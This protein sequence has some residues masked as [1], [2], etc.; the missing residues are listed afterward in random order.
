MKNILILCMALIATQAV[1]QA[2]EKIETREQSPC[3]TIRWEESRSFTINAKLSN[4]T[5]IIL[6]EKIL[7]GF[8][9]VVGNPGLWDVEGA[10]A[11]LY[12]KPNSTEGEGASTTISVVGESGA[13]YDFQAVRRTD[14]VERCLRVSNGAVF[15]GA[16]AA[17]LNTFQPPE[18]RRAQAESTI[19]KTKY[20]EL[21]AS[22]KEQLSNA[23]TEALRRYRY[24]I[25][26]RYN[27]QTKKGGFIGTNLVSDV[28]DDGRFT[29]I[30][31]INDNKGLLTV[32]A[33]L[34]GK[35]EVVDARYDD[36][37]R[38]YRII[39]IYPKF[40][41]KYGDSKLLINRE[42]NITEG[43]F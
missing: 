31:L 34:S 33:D 28:Y 9:P 17:A 22:H 4:Y 7:P 27:W 42:N 25:Y 2:A 10:G 43:S 19:W 6:P 38:M 40:T 14:G 5:H 3:V 23:V 32:E 35:T 36:V 37:S 8:I 41:M 39:G 15:A 29:Y 20:S 26:T 24:H 13:A 1:A 12:V 16:T 21:E 11:H 30:R 18:V